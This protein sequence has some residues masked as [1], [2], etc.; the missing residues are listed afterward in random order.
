MNQ[1]RQ[2]FSSSMSQKPVAGAAAARKSKSG[3]AKSSQSARMLGGGAAAG[4]AALTLLAGGGCALKAKK[5]VSAAALYKQL[6]EEKQAKRYEAALE[7]FEQIRK[8]FPYS[9]YNPQI[10]LLL[11]DIHFEMEKYEAA[12]E[13]YKRF[14]RIHPNLK[15][16]E[17]LKKTALCYMRRLPSSA[18]RDI[19]LADPALKYFNDL[20][21][22]PGKS[23][24]KEEAKKHIKRLLDMKAEK[25]FL[26]ASFYIRRGLRQAAAGRLKGLIQSY[27]ES[28]FANK[29]R[30]LLPK[31]E[32]GEGAKSGGGKTS[33]AESAKMRSQPRNRE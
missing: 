10:R 29:A 31:A 8:N 30:K 12:G 1:E 21:N 13:V 27:P 15:T 9:S 25:E 32:G 6:A 26:I 24:H 19:S 23:N 4:L 5:P 20:L 7:T 33:G 16:A 11:G 17:V 2:G 3:R 28:P 14:L 18:D 22:L